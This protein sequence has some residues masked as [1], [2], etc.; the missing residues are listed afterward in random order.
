MGLT[1]ET[2]SRAF[3]TIG[4]VFEGLR[5]NWK[6]SREFEKLGRVFKICLLSKIVYNQQKR[7][8]VIN[9]FCAR[10]WVQTVPKPFPHPKLDTTIL[11]CIIIPE[12]ATICVREYA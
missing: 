11:I 1:F 12:Y 3:E 4:R 5:E 6:L 9:I 7:I 2:L 10:F 8:N